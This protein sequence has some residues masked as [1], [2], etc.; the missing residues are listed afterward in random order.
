[1][2]YVSSNEGIFWML[3]AAFVYFVPFEEKNHKKSH[4]RESS[5]ILGKFSY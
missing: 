4:L 5:E 1:M 3:Y 2:G